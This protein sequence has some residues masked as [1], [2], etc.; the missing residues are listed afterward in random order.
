MMIELTSTPIIIMV[1]LGIA[2]MIIPV[3]NVVRKERGS[4]TFYYRFYTDSVADAAIFSSDVLVDD[5]FGSFFAIAMLIVSIMAVAGSFNYMR[6]KSNP[7]IYFSL[8]LLSSIGM[9]LI[10]F[11]TDL[12][13]L[14]VAW[15]LMSIPTYIL[16][17]Y[18]KKDPSSNEAAIKYF[19]FGAISSCIRNYRFYKHR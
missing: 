1:I 18:N 7:A 9:V 13:M 10:A 4:S 12:V 2:G 17:G 16:A 3:I 6:N 8:I 5:G 14:F 15:E 19:L 11:S